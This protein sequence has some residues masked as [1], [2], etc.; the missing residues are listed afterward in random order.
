MKI[1]KTHFA[2]L[3]AFLAIIV[4]NA[5]AGMSGVSAPSILSDVTFASAAK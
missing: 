2:C 4:V 5:I 1:T 3:A